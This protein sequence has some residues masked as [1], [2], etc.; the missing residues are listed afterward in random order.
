MADNIR[1]AV[2]E[3]LEELRKVFGPPANTYKDEYDLTPGPS[4]EDLFTAHELRGCGGDCPECQRERAERRDDEAEG[5]DLDPFPV[6][7]TPA[8]ESTDDEAEG[9]GEQTGSDQAI[10][11]SIGL[12]DESPKEA[13]HR[14]HEE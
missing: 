10:M 13:Q 7:E 12:V 4:D 5:D 8:P 9:S 11:D 1:D 3:Q 14:D 2:A 6:L